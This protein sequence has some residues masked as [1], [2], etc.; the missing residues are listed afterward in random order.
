MAGSAAAAAAPEALRRECSAVRLRRPGAVLFL[1]VSVLLLLHGGAVL[2]GAAAVTEYAMSFETG[3]PSPDGIGVSAAAPA[4]V[5]FDW[6]STDAAR[7]G[8]RGLAVTVTNPADVPSTV[9]FQASGG[10]GNGQVPNAHM[11]F[12]SVLCSCK[13]AHPSMRRERPRH[14]GGGGETGGVAC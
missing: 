4:V 9:T 10:P 6:G 12:N 1:L 14:V 3:A 7:T 8:A 5:A 11:E 13:R 2:R